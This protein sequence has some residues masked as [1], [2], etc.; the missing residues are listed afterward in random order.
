VTIASEGEE[1]RYEFTVSGELE[2]TA[3][4]DATIGREDTVEGHTASGGV[5]DGID[6]Y[7][8]DG[9]ITDF[10]LDGSAAV[11]LNGEVV[12]PD[13][14][15]ARL[16]VI[17]GE[18]EWT[19]YELSVSGDLEKTTDGGASLNQF[20]TVDGGDAAG[21]VYGGSDAYRFDGEVTDFTLDGAAA[22]T[23]D[24]EAV[25]PESLD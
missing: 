10:T 6:A 15:G 20:D 18:E 1:A 13:T 2:Q 22:V 16:L 8:F 9:E 23:L 25:D 4:G 24:G 14:V 17:Q 12:D 19:S 11:S 5:W 21:N 7:R 3:A